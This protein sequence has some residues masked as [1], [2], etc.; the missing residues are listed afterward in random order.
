M[1][2]KYLLLFC[3]V[4]LLSYCLF[5]SD[6]FYT[7]KKDND[8]N[9]D[10]NIFNTEDHIIDINPPVIIID[11]HENEMILDN[12]QAPDSIV[13]QMALVDVEYF[14]F[15]SLIHQGQIIVHNTVAEEVSLIFKEL[16]IAKFPIEKVIP[17]V[18]YNWD[19]DLSMRDNNTS[20]F[21]YRSATN[22]GKLSSHALGL[23]IDINPRL[24]PYVDRSGK[25][26]PTNG[27]Y[28]TSQRGTITDTSQC[29]RIFSEYG[30]KWGGHW[31]YSKDYQHFSK[32]GK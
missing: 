13:N 14:G 12:L 7:V 9:I 19:D 30:W 22:S 6:I 29:F 15:D 21:N 11:Y 28:N 3:V 5:F 10:T 31:R 20:S 17:V 25:I 16:F 24:N 23:A 8:L 32:D 2:I 18:S 4:G 26:Y 27:V 1:R